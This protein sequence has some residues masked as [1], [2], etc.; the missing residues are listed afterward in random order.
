MKKSFLALGIAFI[1]LTS[2]KQFE[3]GEGDMLYKM[4][5]DKE[6]PKIKEGDFVALR[7]V[8]KTEE[9]SI[10][11]SSY[12]YDRPSLLVKEKSLFKGDLYAALGMLSEG[13][14]ATFKI[15]ADSMEKKMGRPKPKNTKGKYYVYDIKVVK[16]IPKGKLDEQAFRTKLNEYMAV[17]SQKV[18]SQEAGKISNYISKNDLKPTVTTSGLNYIVTKKG[19]GPKAKVGDSIV[20]NYTGRF[21]NGK[22]FDTS[23]K[24]VAEKEKVFNPQRPYEPMRVPAGTNS[25]IPGFDEA[26]LLFPKGTEVTVIIPSKLGYGEQGS[27]AIPPF[28]PLVF[29]LEIMNVIPAKAGSTATP[30]PVTS[31]NTTTPNQKQ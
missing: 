2:C 29:E 7:A 4:Y 26:L 30:P 14:S 20:L 21:L 23:D 18:K 22:V 8:E 27:Q 24:V 15:N 25:T 11:Y 13:D 17:E 16:V 10:I 19:T 28:S 31:Q 1:A 6:G 5:E 3:K 12:E 9:D